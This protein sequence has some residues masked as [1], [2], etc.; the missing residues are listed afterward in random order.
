MFN[1]IFNPYKNDYGA[2]E[3][4]LILVNLINYFTYLIIVSG[5]VISNNNYII[6]NKYIKY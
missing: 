2:I 6:I 1:Y 4:D 5:Y 3:L